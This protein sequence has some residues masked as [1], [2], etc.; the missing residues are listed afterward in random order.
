MKKIMLFAGMLLALQAFSQTGQGSAKITPHKTIAAN[1]MPADK[2]KMLCKAWVL[3]SVE[4]FGV[5]HTPNAKEKNDGVTFMADG[6]FFTTS[7]GVAGTGTWK[8]NGNPYINTSVGTP[9]VKKMFKIMVLSDSKLVLEYQTE[10]LIRI[11]YTYIPK[12]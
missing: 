1:T 12:Q 9:E 8:G 3:D 10:D 2:S 6:T 11:H 4:Q 5:A 7:E